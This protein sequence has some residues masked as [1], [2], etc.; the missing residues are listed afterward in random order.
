MIDEKGHVKLT[1]Y[2]L[3]LVESVKQQK[4]E[5]EEQKYVSQF[6]KKL[7][8]SKL[9]MSYEGDL[10]KKKKEIVGSPYFMSP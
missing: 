3:S 2:G 9:K 6:V 8:R 5:E 10:S 1:D 7:R 4:L